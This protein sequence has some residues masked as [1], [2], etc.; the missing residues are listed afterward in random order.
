MKHTK[1]FWSGDCLMESDPEHFSSSHILELGRI[2]PEDKEKKL[3]AASP[4][5][6]KR[7]MASN[8]AIRHWIDV[9]ILSKEQ[10]E[11]INRNL[12]AIKKATS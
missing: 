7:L 8:E 11:I 2:K 9:G 3:I 4:D 12:E 6:L 5:L 1:W 10:N